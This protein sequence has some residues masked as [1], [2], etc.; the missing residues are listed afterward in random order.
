MQILH[1]GLDPDPALSRV[2]VISGDLRLMDMDRVKFFPDLLLLH[3]LDLQA[4]LIL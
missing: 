3:L 2:F 4:D 1:R